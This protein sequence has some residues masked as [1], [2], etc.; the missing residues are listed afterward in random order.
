MFEA[1]FLFAIFHLALVQLGVRAYWEQV[2]RDLR[3]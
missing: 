3:R 2:H 1:F